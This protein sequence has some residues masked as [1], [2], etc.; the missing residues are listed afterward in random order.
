MR[1]ARFRSAWTSARVL[2]G[3]FCGGFVLGVEEYSRVSGRNAVGCRSRL[4]V[5]KER[6]RHVCHRV[7]VVHK[8]Y[9]ERAY[10]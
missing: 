7:R 1:R 6:G 3:P 2:L 5:N 9:S 4:F 10:R 8:I